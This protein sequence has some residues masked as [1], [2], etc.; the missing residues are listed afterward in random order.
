MSTQ[1]P[2]F[3]GDSFFLNLWQC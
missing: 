3:D 2:L 1:I